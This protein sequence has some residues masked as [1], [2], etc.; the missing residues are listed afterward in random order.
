MRF[1]FNTFNR[2]Q[3]RGFTMVEIALC[4]AIVAFAMVVIMGVL[5]LGGLVQ[6]ENREKTLSLLDGNYILEAIQN[7]AKGYDDLGLYVDEILLFEKPNSAPKVIENNVS[8]GT[9]WGTREIVGLLSAP[10]YLLTSSNVWIPNYLNNNSIFGNRATNMTCRL[11]MRSMNGNAADKN[12]DEANR[13]FGMSYLV[14]VQVT[15]A[16]TN[17]VDLDEVNKDST[18]KDWFLRERTMSRTTY[19]VLLTLS[20]PVR[21]TASKDG[22]YVAGNNTQFFRTFIT[23]TLSDT[24]KTMEIP[25]SGNKDVLLWY[26]NQHEFSITNTTGFYDEYVQ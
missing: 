14:D 25:D 12:T 18:L 16:Q 21:Q 3:Q 15:P 4:L 10:K 9:Y 13:D 8:G 20:W 26:F 22:Y 6:K 23:G 19:E 17:Y 11:K 24:K 1:F 2:A 5:P 7:G